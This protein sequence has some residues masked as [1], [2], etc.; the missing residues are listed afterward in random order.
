MQLGTPSHPCRFAVRYSHVT[1]HD[2]YAANQSS[3][4]FSN[5]RE[6]RHQSRERGAS[7]ANA[8][9]LSSSAKMFHRC[10]E[11]KTLRSSPMRSIVLLVLILCQC[12][13]L[14]IACADDISV[15]AHAL[16]LDGNP[17]QPNSANISAETRVVLE[18]SL[19]NLSLISKSFGKLSPPAV[20]R[21]L[22][23][24][25]ECVWDS[26]TPF[27]DAW[28]PFMAINARI[29]RVP[30]EMRTVD[31]Q[32]RAAAVASYHALSFLHQQTV[33]QFLNRTAVLLEQLGYNSSELTV[34]WTELLSSSIPKD[35]SNDSLLAGLRWNSTSPLE[36]A[37]LASA[38]ILAFRAR[39][40]M[41]QFGDEPTTPLPATAYADYS[42][43][44][45]VN[46]PQPTITSTDCG[47]LRSINHW[48]PLR[49]P[50]A[51]SNASVV[52]KFA[53]PQ[54]YLLKPFA[55]DY[56]GQFR[57]PPPPMYGTASEDEFIKEFTSV[58]I[59]LYLVWIRAS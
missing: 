16:L 22:A 2:G 15:D 50:K 43:Y 38:N 13:L 40:G 19:E 45:P 55:M 54:A 34:N 58:M 20:A 41:N 29:Q 28:T 49:L 17:D 33:P 1:H 12:T 36:L 53:S 37:T 3:Y 9:A 23:T 24:H 31:N 32:M 44:V 47:A 21:A 35:F 51:D 56:A 30:L 42:N 57:P 10:F 8:N 18:W 25:W 46:D 14:P 48:Q 5:G 4:I 11:Q 7:V 59:I 52:Q 39:D 26:V 6:N 27:T